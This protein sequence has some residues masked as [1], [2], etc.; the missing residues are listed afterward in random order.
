MAALLDETT[1]SRSLYTLTE[2][3][4]MVRADLSFTDSSFLTDANITSWLNRAQDRLARVLRWYR[5][6]DVM[7]TTADVKEYALP[8]PVTGRC[9]QIEEIRYND[10]Q[11]EVITLDQLRMW[12]YNYQ[13]SG[14]GTPQWYYLRGNNGFGL[15]VTPDTT[16]ADILTVLYV[17]LPPAV[18]GSSSLFYVPQGGDDYLLAYAK[19]LASQKDMYGEGA[20]RVPEYHR[21]CAEILRELQRQVDQSAERERVVLGSDALEFDGGRGQVPYNSL[22]S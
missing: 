17:G 2:L 11:L 1:A 4:D 18:S 16:D 6:H 10:Q 12:D 3:R 8:T 9:I 13:S 14:T 21:E 22:I 7:G 5:V 19:L 15:H 20:R